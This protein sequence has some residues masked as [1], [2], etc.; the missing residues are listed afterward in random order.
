MK[1][2]IVPLRRPPPLFSM[3]VCFFFGFLKMLFKIF[4][5]R[6]R[7]YAENK[8]SARQNLPAPP[9]SSESNCRTLVNSVLFVI[10]R[11]HPSFTVDNP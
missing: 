5:I 3:Y 7:C 2:P 6:S 9:P 4:W 10:K 11:R 8:L 1:H